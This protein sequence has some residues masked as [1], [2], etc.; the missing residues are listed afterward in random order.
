LL[1][2]QDASERKRLEQSLKTVTSV[3]SS[4]N[5]SQETLDLNIRSLN[6][7]VKRIKFVVE[8]HEAATSF[9]D[10]TDYEKDL[11][12]IE[13]DVNR[14]QHELQKKEQNT[15]LLR[16]QV[17][18]ISKDIESMKKSKDELQ[19]Y[20]SKLEIVVNSMESRTN[21]SFQRID[22]QLME[23]E[24]SIQSLSEKQFNCEKRLTEVHELQSTVGGFQRMHEELKCRV[25]EN[26]KT[27][28]NGLEQIDKE[29]HEAIGILRSEQ[30][31]L[32]ESLKDLKERND[33]LNSQ[34]DIAIERER[35]IKE[36]IYF[37]VEQ[38]ESTMRAEEMRIRQLTLEYGEQFPKFIE[39]KRVQDDILSTLPR[40]EKEL[41]ANASVLEGKMLIYLALL[42]LI[43][44]QQSTVS[45]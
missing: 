22:Q 11:R 30:V 41:E 18:E 7:D 28:T 2:K 36:E 42:H 13:Q 4:L 33:T 21:A 10:K 5:S 37:K 35:L 23:S 31:P 32:L 27:V 39:Q 8:T 38:M 29:C 1:L 12:H 25:S 15:T 14:V 19:E 34:F 43:I 24:Q 3:V 26:Y 44:V 6:D 40:L 20:M 16:E 45:R 9:A 17:S